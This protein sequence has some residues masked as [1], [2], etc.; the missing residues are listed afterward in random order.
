M[1]PAVA[2]WAYR[3]VTPQPVT[4]CRNFLEQQNT[5]GTWFIANRH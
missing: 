1:V 3:W 4:I 2:H 5:L